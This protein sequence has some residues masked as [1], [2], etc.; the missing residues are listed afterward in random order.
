MIS[1]IVNV[2]LGMFSGAGVAGIFANL[3]KE[4]LLALVM[5]IEWKV[6]I[7]RATTRIVVA[8][9][10]RLAAL[11]TNQLL[12]ETVEDFVNQLQSK[13]LK[14]ANQTYESAKKYRPI[15]STE[16]S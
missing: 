9:L 11:S 3:V 16:S 6:V 13:G 15:K 8:G 14:Q 12:T 10:H 1:A 7:E 2:I 5:K 4:A